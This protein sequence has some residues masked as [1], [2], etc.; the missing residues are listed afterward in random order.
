MRGRVEA[1]SRTLDQVATKLE[2]ERKNHEK[3]MNEYVR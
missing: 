3:T 1:L 2:N